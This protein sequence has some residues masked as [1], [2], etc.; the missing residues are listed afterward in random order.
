MTK[1]QT[2]ADELKVSHQRVAQIEK[3]ILEKMRKALKENGYD[4][5]DLDTF[6]TE[7][8]AHAYFMQDWVRKYD[9]QNIFGE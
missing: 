4:I 8:L 6:N 5:A 9:H 1:L 7:F 3:C 2:I